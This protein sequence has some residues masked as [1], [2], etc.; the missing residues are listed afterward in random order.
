MNELAAAAVVYAHRGWFVFPLVPRRKVPLTTHGLNDASCDPALVAG[1]W[2]EQPQ[3]NIGVAC[4]PSGLLVVDVDG[5][6]AAETWTR[7]AGSNGGYQSTLT[8]KT[9]N[10][11]HIYFTGPG[12]SSAGRLGRRID[13]RG[14]GGYVVAPPS[15]H[16]SGH[17]YRWLDAAAPVTA[18]PG[19]VSAALEL[20][21]SAAA[22]MG[23]ARRLPDGAPYTAYGLIALA[24]IVDEM[25]AAAEGHR[26]HTLNALAYRSGRLVAAGEIAEEVAFEELVDAALATGLDPDETS[27]T[28][29]SGFRAGLQIPAQVGE[30]REPV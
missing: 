26:N 23:A 11:F 8:A 16:E 3:A 1:W 19:W 12:R 27:R 25:A 28:F 5:D 2:R 14:V 18:A 17:M 29:A 6:E 21:A 9:G 20:P 30:R 10:G 24:G 7:I 13:T 22:P 4:G 15:I